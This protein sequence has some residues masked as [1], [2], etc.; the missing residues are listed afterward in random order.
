MWIFREQREVAAGKKIPLWA[1]IWIQPIMPSTVL[2]WAIN[3]LRIFLF[4]CGSSDCIRF[5]L[6][7]PQDLP[8]NPNP[9][10]C[11]TSYFFGV[12]IKFF[13][14]SVD[15]WE[16]NPIILSCIW[17]KL[18]WL[19]S[20]L[21]LSHRRFRKK[22][23]ANVWSFPLA[24]ISHF[25]C[26]VC[27]GT[28]LW[29]SIQAVCKGGLRILVKEAGTHWMKQHITIQILPLMKFSDNNIHEI[30]LQKSNEYREFCQALTD[31]NRY[32]YL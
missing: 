6:D 18:W 11:W 10:Q 5:F 20:S 31:L 23:K 26:L 24:L 21:A 8:V 25:I 15:I 32:A 22:E 13:I 3:S 19:G 9:W 2:F 17:I 7:T 27:L 16:I 28:C 29:L 14:H 30:T 12:W 4:G 1:P